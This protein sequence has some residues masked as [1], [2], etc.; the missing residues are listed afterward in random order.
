MRKAGLFLALLA[1]LSL[2]VAPMASAATPSD[3]EAKIKA[4]EQQLQSMKEQLKQVQSTQQQQQQQAV[5]AAAQSKLPA[6]VERITLFGDV[7]FRYEHTNYDDLNGKSKDGKDRFRI[8]LRF[9]ARSQIHQDVEVGF[10][11]ATGSDTDPTSTNQTMGGYFGE[12][13]NW[14]LDQAYVKYTPS[15]MPQRMAT[16]SFGKVPNP[17]VTSKII[18][19][20]DVVPE[21]AFLNFTFNKDGNVRPFV[22]ATYMTVSEDGEFGDNVLAPALQAGAKGKLGAFDFTGAAG[23]TSWGNLGDNGK[24]PPNLHGT[25]TYVEGGSERTTNY[26][27]VDVYAKGAFKFSKKGSVGLWGQW[28]KN[29]DSEGPYQSKD[30]GYGAAAFVTYDKFKFEVLYKNVEANA[31]PGFIADSDSGYVNRKGWQVEGQYKMW[32]Y[33]KLVVTY[34][35]TE[36]EDESIPGASNPSQTIFVNTIFKF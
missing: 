29:Q 35:N 7:R 9:G 32:K 34:Y 3:L 26:A 36:P 8:R 15:F 33:G 13:S 18:W 19:D 1:A 31:T 16:F 27:V 2:W 20:S 10:R 21:G 23:Y 12:F 17:L 22:T 24:L 5:E 28:L 25:P 6:W 30:Q 4:M 14:G 11:M